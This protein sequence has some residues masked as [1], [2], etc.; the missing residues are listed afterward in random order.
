MTSRWAATPMIVCGNPHI[1]H[2]HTLALREAR[3]L[4]LKRASKRP[5][6]CSVATTTIITTTTTTAKY[7]RW[8][9]SNTREHRT[10]E[11]WV[12]EWCMV[13][14]W[15]WCGDVDGGDVGGGVLVVIVTPVPVNMYTYTC[16][17]C[18]RVSIYRMELDWCYS[19]KNCK[20]RVRGLI[21]INT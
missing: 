11:E 20:C 18:A 4:K 21:W 16:A 17:G 13:T 6:R 8:R 12:S 15:L 5:R 19:F 10:A 7:I 9:A 1:P 14:V 2:T 3:M